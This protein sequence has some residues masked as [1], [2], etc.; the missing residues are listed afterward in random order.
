MRTQVLRQ[1][2]SNHRNDF[3]DELL[4]N[5][6]E[7]MIVRSWQRDQSANPGERLASCYE[8]SKDV[9]VL[10]EGWAY[11]FSILSGGRR[12]ILDFLLPGDLFSFASV[13]DGR[14]SFS[15]DALTE[16]RVLKLR[17]TEVK[18]RLAFSTNLQAKW[19]EGVA[20]QARI[21]DELL[22]SL[23]QR[24]AE[25]RVGYL[26]LHLMRR[27]S[28]KGLANEHRC[29]FPLKQPHIGDAL[30]I[31]SEH[32]CRMISRFRKRGILEISSGYVEVFDRDAL[33]RIASPSN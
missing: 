24:T 26:I 2:C 14:L 29:F 8:Y 1:V 33:K 7:S 17:R 28:D 5:P 18:R 20:H 6:R 10:R 9:L 11:R 25:E 16:V 19:V 4:A 22:V 32:V 3:C 12:Q 21:V 30:G 31:T 13:F 15:V 27:M 23:G